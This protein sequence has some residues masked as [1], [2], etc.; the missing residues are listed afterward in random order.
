MGINLEQM[1]R[2]ELLSLR[3][4][5]EKALVSAEKRERQE[6]LKAAEK[7]AAE[8]GFSLSELSSDAPR[9]GKTPKTKAKY[10]NPSNPEQT[11]T[12]R[13]R[14]PQWVHDALKAGADISELEI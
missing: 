14:K 10:R 4:E 2:K 7:A 1:S 8:F 12:G 9:G 11:W 6:A 13:G 5:I 3:D